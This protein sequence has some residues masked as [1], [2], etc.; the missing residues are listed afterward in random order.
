MDRRGLLGRVLLLTGSAAAFTVGMVE[1]DERSSDQL[2]W[3]SSVGE[4]M[5]TGVLPIRWSAPVSTGHTAALTFDDGPTA[6]FTAELLQTLSRHDIRATFF[7]IGALVERHPDLVR[8]VVDAGHEL[9]NHTYDHESAA[10]RT[11]AQVI[12]SVH[13]G[14]ETIQRVSGIAPRWLRPPRGEI[15]TATLIAARQAELEVAL[16]SVNRGHGPDADANAVA[17]HLSTALRPGSVV[18]LHDGIGRS[19]WVGHPDQHLITRRR[20]ELD[21]LPAALESWL[22]AGYQFQTLSQLIPRQ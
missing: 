12:T 4:Q 9:A 18:D 21:A 2:R 19:S 22:A 13:R 5:S 16:W 11:A 20:A 15:T 14:S 7:M 17:A 8:R 1:H 3:R 10:V 6:Q